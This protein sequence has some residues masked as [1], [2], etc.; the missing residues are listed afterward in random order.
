MIVLATWTEVRGDRF[1]HDLKLGRNV[2]EDIAN[3]LRVDESGDPI[4][5]ARQE[6]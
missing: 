3:R 2:I 1:R 6:P 4:Q 5:T